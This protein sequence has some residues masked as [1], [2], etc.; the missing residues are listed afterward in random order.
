MLLALLMKK[1]TF[2]EKA[3]AVPDTAASVTGKKKSKRDR[4]NV[5]LVISLISGILSPCY[6]RYIITLLY[7]VYH[8]PAISGIS[9]PCYIRYIITLLYPVPIFAKS[10]QHHNHTTPLIRD[11]N[12]ISSCLS[13][14]H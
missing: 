12:S 5:R 9:S 4:D 11:L 3:D 7:P 14:P 6:I 2:E 8:H 1:E 13:E 10:P